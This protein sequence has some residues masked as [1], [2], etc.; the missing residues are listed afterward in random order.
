MGRTRWVVERTFGRL[1]Q[2]KRLRLRCERR[3]GL[4]QSLLE[5]ACSNIC[6]PH[7]RG[8]GG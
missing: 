7:L 4:H 5:L 8:A 1:H 2:F 3:A 6:L